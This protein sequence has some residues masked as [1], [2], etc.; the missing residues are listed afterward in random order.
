METKTLI[1]RLPKVQ[2]HD[3]LDGGL[4][5]QTIIELAE[6]YKYD[7]L[8][9]KDPKVLSDWFFEGA[10]KGNLKD[11]LRGF[12][13]TIAV[14]QK[15]EALERIAYE[16]LEDAK[17][18]GVVYIET[19][20]APVF[21]TMEGLYYDEVLDAVITGLEKG[22]KD[23]GVGYG[24]IL[25]GM[26]NIK[27]NLNIAELAV[28]FRNQGV[29]GFD[30]AGEEGGYPPKNHL[31]SFNFIQR[32]N[33]NITIHAG[34]AFGK[35]S[36]WQALQFCGAHRVGHATRLTE[37]IYYDED[38]NIVGMGDLAQYILDKR[39]PLE[40]CLLSNVHTGAID[41]LE[42]HPFHDLFTQKFRVFLN[43]DDRLMSDTTLSKEYETAAKLWGLDINDIEKMTINAMKSAFIPYN[44]RLKYIYEVIK[45]GFQEIKNELLVIK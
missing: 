7:K 24:L 4:R 42:N 18:D 37:D 35:E 45:P 36:I 13:H 1:E 31:E 16:M 43:T 26:R 27:D 39:I 6:E 15:R 22:K 38:G 40:I 28:N 34:E 19:R 21:H 17:K 14:M 2:L 9:T 33:F 11:Y 25:C 10:N 3:H 30:L 23:F 12:E 29:V 32:E 41:Q 20:F 5:P 44:E 8:P